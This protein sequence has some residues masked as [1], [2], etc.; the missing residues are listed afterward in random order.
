MKKHI[1]ATA[2]CGGLLSS[3]AF[4]AGPVIPWGSEQSRA[5]QLSTQYRQYA[6]GI[7]RGK[8]SER[9][10]SIDGMYSLSTQGYADAIN[11]VG[12]LLDNGIGVNRD[13][14]KAA[15]YFQEAAKRGSRIASHN[16][17]V[18][19]LTGRGIASNQEA[20]MKL[21]KQAITFRVPEAS[22]VT[23]LYYES[24]KEYG[25]AAMSYGEATGVNNH[26]IAKARLGILLVKGL[27]VQ[28]NIREGRLLLEQAAN[29][30]WPEAQWT[31][32][33]MSKFGIGGKPNLWDAGY[34]LTILSKN[35]FLGRVDANY[36]N[37]A[38]NSIGGLGLNE[39]AWKEIN[40]SVGQWVPAHN[41]YPSQFDYWQSVSGFTE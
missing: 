21:L 31:L 25:R 22:I 12:Y 8:E 1:L 10:Q 17:G 35:P 24:Q 29:V 34:W 5:S 23:G 11:F 30:W 39:Q 26:P 15:I 19:T 38:R 6:I 27:G 40:G 18:L 13:S 3:V 36:A 9:R 16:L 20:A 14:S 4:A 37:L 41:R 2:L 7:L 32:A 28:Q 33:E